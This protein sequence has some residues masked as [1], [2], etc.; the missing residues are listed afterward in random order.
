MIYITIEKE[1][2]KHPL[3]LIENN[4][5]HILLIFKQ[6]SENTW[7]KWDSNKSKRFAWDNLYEKHVLQC[8]AWLKGRKNVKLWS[9]NINLDE[10]ETS[11]EFRYNIA[12]YLDE[13]DIAYGNYGKVNKILRFNTH[14]NGYTKILTFSDK[15]KINEEK[16]IE[17]HTPELMINLEFGG[18]GLSLICDEDNQH[19]KL[20][21]EII[22]WSIKDWYAILIDFKV[23]V[24]MI[25]LEFGGIGLSL[26][27]DE[28]NQHLKLRKEIIVWSIKDWY[29]I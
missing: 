17:D 16:E 4:A 5:K 23:E 15:I 10:L 12:E 25:N 26:I 19:L 9:V 27:C 11:E 18:I 3:Y 1:D 14:T 7:E 20:R 29:A 8:E 22:V 28:D 2:E 6:L 13:N 21:K 24:L